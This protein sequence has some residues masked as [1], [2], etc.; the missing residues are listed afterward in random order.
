MDEAKPAVGINDSSNAPEVLM[1]SPQGHSPHRGENPIASLS[2][3]NLGYLTSPKRR[4]PATPTRNDDMNS[5]HTFQNNI[6][7]TRIDTTSALH[8]PKTFSAINSNSNNNPGAQT[9]Q[10]P[11]SPQVRNLSVPLITGLGV[12][13]ASSTHT[14][15]TTTTTITTGGKFFD[16]ASTGDKGRHRVNDAR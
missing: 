3:N 9:T 4:A 5:E 16:A 12:P 13:T 11:A 14:G 1:V 2:A 8:I 6:E 15:N 10:I 7:S